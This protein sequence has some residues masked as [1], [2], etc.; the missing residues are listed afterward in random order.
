MLQF[1]RGQSLAVTPG[2]EMGDLP[3]A[4]RHHLFLPNKRCFVLFDGAQIPNLPEL[5]EAAEIEHTSL[6]KGLDAIA[7]ESAGPWLAS[8]DP[9]SKFTANIFV[10]GDAPWH[11]WD[12]CR[13]VF[14]SSQATLKELR[15]HLRHFTLLNTP[16]GNRVFFRFWDG[17]IM[18]DYLVGC[19]DD[20]DRAARFYGTHKLSS[21]ALVECF[22]TRSNL[23]T[24]ALIPFR[25][26]GDLAQHP[27]P[28]SLD[29]TDLN[30]LQS[31]ADNRF[32]TALSGRL[33]HRFSEVD[34]GQAHYAPNLAHAALRFV[35]RYGANQSVDLERDCF[36]LALMAFLL[37]PSR[38]KVMQGP[39]MKEPLIPIS[40]RI[41][42][43]RE[44]YFLALSKALP[45]E[46]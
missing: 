30:I 23:H 46:E 44:S 45:T 31:A 39:L 6:F 36:E 43:L 37:G 34:P 17:Q 35:R 29:H 24:D 11:L 15:Q 19:A 8:L 18:T 9:A 10:K 7:Y 38:D 32:V 40:H 13:M 42:L 27:G 4:I 16:S 26:S 5:L 25:I 2:H 20:P 3:E 1:E 14:L 41:A 22:W 21:S 33:H 12:K 28:V